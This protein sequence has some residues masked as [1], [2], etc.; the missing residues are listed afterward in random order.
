MLASATVALEG[1]MLAYAWYGFYA[2]PKRRHKACR[3]VSFMKIMVGVILLSLLKWWLIDV[4]F[5]GILS[6]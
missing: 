2:H 6:G 5:S 4:P 1:G 3:A